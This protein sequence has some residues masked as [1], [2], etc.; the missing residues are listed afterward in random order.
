MQRTLARHRSAADTDRLARADRRESKTRRRRRRVHRRCDRTA[1]AS[2]QR[3]LGDPAPA[4]SEMCVS[5]PGRDRADDGSPMP[6]TALSACSA[7]FSRH[8]RHCRLPHKRH[9]V[10][11]SRRMPSGLFLG[12]LSLRRSGFEPRDARLRHRPLI[13][14]PPSSARRLP[15]MNAAPAP[16][17]RKRS[18]SLASTSSPSKRARPLGFEPLPSGDDDDGALGR[19]RPKRLR[20]VESGCPFDYPSYPVFPSYPA[21]TRSDTLTSSAAGHVVGP[22]GDD[23]DDVKE[24]KSAVRE[25]IRA[26]KSPLE[27][28]TDEITSV[29]EL[30]LRGAGIVKA[31]QTHC[32][33]GSSSV[34]RRLTVQAKAT[35][36]PGRI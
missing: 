18:P 26:S 2:W 36:L 28:L 31:M 12:P 16:A 25:A 10:H 34:S 17:A 19:A 22:T 7:V 6:L 9:T 14:P 33:P 21:P 27:R 35:R 3:S 13:K 20:S 30:R 5:T 15:E 11:A 32:M 1:S 29:D 8:A 23:E 24:S 4:T